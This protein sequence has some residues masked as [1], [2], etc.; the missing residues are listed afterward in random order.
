MNHYCR[1][2]FLSFIF[3]LSVSNCETPVQPTRF[4][5]VEHLYVSF[6]GAKQLFYKWKA[7][8]QLPVAW[9]FQDWGGFQSG[10]LSMG[11]LVIE[12]IEP[13]DS[14]TP[15]AYGL[16]LEPE[17]PHSNM[18]R[19]LDQLQCPH[20]PPSKG[21]GWSTMSLQG[22]LPE[23]VNVFSCDYADRTKVSKNRADAAD[24]LAKRNGGALGIISVKSIIIPAAPV[25]EYGAQWSRLPG[26][27]LLDNVVSF[28]K[29]PSIHLVP[30][31]SKFWTLE[32]E[33]DPLY[34]THE[35]LIALGYEPLLVEGHSELKVSD[36]PFILRFL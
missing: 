7:D 29:G 17:T 33:T 23:S 36:L 10:G 32:L 30:D 31:T 35:R 8:W 27:K 15:L 22:V 19:Y 18:R 13:S 34:F 24:L 4:T 2:T 11:N 28:S 1:I 21:M 9:E 16:A 26:C 20:G 14:S 6:P 25:N 5:K 12:L 3:L